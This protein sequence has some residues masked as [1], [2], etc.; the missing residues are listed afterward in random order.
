MKNVIIIGAGL[1]GLT[2]SL[3]LAEKGIKSNY[4][5]QVTLNKANQSWLWE[6]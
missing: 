2:C 4:F 5:H 6:E 1:A 3:K